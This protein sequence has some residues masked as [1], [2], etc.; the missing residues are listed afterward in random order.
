MR[1]W[2]VSLDF[3]HHGETVFRLPCLLSPHSADDGMRICTADGKFWLSVPTLTISRNRSPS[4]AGASE[5]SSLPPSTSFMQRI[6]SAGE[7]PSAYSWQAAADAM[8]ALSRLV[9]GGRNVPP[10][11]RADEMGFNVN[12][13]RFG[14][15]KSPADLD[16]HAVEA[17]GFNIIEDR[18]ERQ[19]TGPLLAPSPYSHSF[20]SIKTASRDAMLPKLTPACYAPGIVQTG[21]CP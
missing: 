1:P 6:M 11:N 2:I 19:G 9:P 12:D 3:L 7:R 13:A 16:R 21:A 10:N 20:A 17:G 18:G 5:Q 8:N 14:I 15:C 4:Q